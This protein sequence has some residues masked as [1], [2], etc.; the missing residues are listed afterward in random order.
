MHLG[1]RDGTGKMKNGSRVTRGA[2]GR[3][4]FLLE[5]PLVRESLDPGAARNGSGKRSQG[6]VP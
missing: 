3:T 4:R 2:V 1:E 5:E 6:A